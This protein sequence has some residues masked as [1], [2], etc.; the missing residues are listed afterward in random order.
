MSFKIA[1]RFHLSKRQVCPQIQEVWW[2]N[3]LQSLHLKPPASTLPDHICSE[4]IRALLCTPKLK[5]IRGLSFQM[6]SVSFLLP[7]F[8]PFISRGVFSLVDFPFV[9][10]SPPSPLCLIALF[11]TPHI[12]CISPSFASLYLLCCIVAAMCVLWDPSTSIFSRVL[13]QQVC[14]KTNS[15]S[16][17]DSQHLSSSVSSNSSSLRGVPRCVL[18]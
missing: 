1:L 5:W 12:F 14:H 6:L 8:Y 16:D 9:F 18:C 2:Q 4:G 10:F 13:V 11:H 3:G 15:D 7:L 17:S